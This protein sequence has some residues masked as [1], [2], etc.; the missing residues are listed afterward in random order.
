[1]PS[2]D[3]VTSPEACPGPDPICEPWEENLGEVLLTREQIQARVVEMGAAVSRDY[4][5]LKPMLVGV[6]RGVF[7]FMADL[8]REITI[9]TTVD[10]I[11]ISRYGPTE[12]TQGVVRFTK[13]LDLPVEDRHV[14]FIEDIVDTG[15]TTAY[16]L[17]SLKARNP[18]SLNVCTLLDRPRRRIVDLNLAYIGFE[19]PDCWV[20]GYGLDYREELRQLPH[21]AVFVPPGRPE[22]TFNGPLAPQVSL[23]PL[24][25]RTIAPTPV[26]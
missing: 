22:P 16:I 20:V 3:D 6:L 23:P 9:P 18:A 7:F 24:T 1:M 8:M 10:F 2:N 11:A 4:A 14:L 13:D 26:P 17:R 19:I 5:G 21:I 12:R 25:P 15:L